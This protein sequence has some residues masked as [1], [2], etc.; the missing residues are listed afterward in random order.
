MSIC[1]GKSTTY[2]WVVYKTLD[3]HSLITAIVFGGLSHVWVKYGQSRDRTD[4]NK[5]NS[6]FLQTAGPILMNCGMAVSSTEKYSIFDSQSSVFLIRVLECLPSDTK[7]HRR[8]YKHKNC[9]KLLIL[10]VF[11]VILCCYCVL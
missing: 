5:S 8:S 4:A 3:L 1:C 9:H 11:D 2:T 6:T 10:C 7:F